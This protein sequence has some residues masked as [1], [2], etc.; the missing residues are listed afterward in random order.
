VTIWPVLS[1]VY[2]YGLRDFVAAER[3]FGRTGWVDRCLVR[4]PAGSKGGL[5]AQR[6]SQAGQLLWDPNVVPLPGGL[7][8]Y[9]SIASDGHGRALFVSQNS[10]WLA[11][12][13]L[14]PNGAAIWP[15]GGAS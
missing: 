2:A 6:M 15:D 8:I 4:Q 3:L 12:Q 10:E 14:D 13:R 11:A 5:H 1:I 9:A 7:S